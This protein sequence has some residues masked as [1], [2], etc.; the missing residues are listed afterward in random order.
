MCV[1]CCFVMMVL[2]ACFVCCC[3]CVVW[4]VLLSFVC[5]WLR[6][7]LVVCSSLFVVSRSFCL[8]LLVDVVS[9]V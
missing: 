8:F 7:L 3:L 5:W 2:V 4:C 9:C 6:F 1:V